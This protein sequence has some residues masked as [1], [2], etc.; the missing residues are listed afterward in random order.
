MVT[1]L[2]TP[3]SHAAFGADHPTRLTNL[4]HAQTP[5]AVV[6]PQSVSV[7]L[8]P[9][10]GMAVTA[11]PVPIGPS[12]ANRSVAPMVKAVQGHAQDYPTSAGKE[13]N[14]ISRPLPA[15]TDPTSAS[16]PVSPPTT[17]VPVTAAEKTRSPLSAQISAYEI[18]LGD[19]Y[20]NLG[21]YDKAIN[22]FSRAI[23]FSP[24]NKEAQERVGRARRAK[25]A[26]D[27]VLQ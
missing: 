14:L 7:A 3:V 10:H 9:T 13:Q 26:E 16:S 5:V 23:M 19:A 24:G 22:C 1:P 15:V 11:P 17:A 4:G 25:A 6:P 20:M 12:I 8:P 18:R 2:S 21:E 27:S